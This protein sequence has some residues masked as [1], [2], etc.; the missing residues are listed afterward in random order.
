MNHTVLLADDSLTIQKVIKITLANQP[1][2]IVDC[3]NEEEL[4]K[5]L[6]EV[7]AKVVFLDFNLSEKYTGYE[8]TT[9]IKSISPS[10]KVLLLLGT[11]DTVDDAAMEKCG[12]SEKIVKPF[13][14][15]KFIAICKQLVDAAG[16]E[17]IRYP[18]VAEKPI[19]PVLPAMDEDQWRVSHTTEH[20]LP[21]A[22]EKVDKTGPFQINELNKEISEWGFNV[23]GVISETNT[24]AGLHPDLLPPVI[25][26]VKSLNAHK[27]RA[28]QFETKFPDN[29]E[30]DYPTIEELSQTS[31]VVEPVK[32]KPHSKLLSLDSLNLAQTDDFEIEHNISSEPE[33]DIKSLEDQIKDEV[34]ENLWQVDEFEE[35]KKEVSA[36][37]DEMKNT[38]QPSRNAFD[39]SLFKPLDEKE[40]NSWSE[41]TNELFGHTQDQARTES[42]AP[43]TADF[44]AEMEEMVKKYVQEYMDQMFQKNVEKISWE[45]IPDLAENLIRQELGKIANKII[46]ENN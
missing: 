46:N 39:E 33:T 7:H 20:K 15:N 14:S 32:E 2:E 22:P 45:V 23:P 26:E 25:G 10:T 42:N 27:T 36:K 43:M 35:L 37:M 38:F 6:T 28:E 18:D 12:A 4:F 40:V 13:D 44:R 1:Y 17:E 11:F 19:K 29:G 21:V 31:P 16:A 3:P 24:D 9:K 5:K 30:L 34:E 8:L 41:S